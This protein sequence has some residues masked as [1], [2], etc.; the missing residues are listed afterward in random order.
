MA[1]KTATNP[2]REPVRDQIRAPLQFDDTDRTRLRTG[3][4]T[5]DPLHISDEILAR[6]REAGRDLN[7]KNCEV[8]GMPQHSY[9]QL[10]LEQGWRPVTHDM[11]PGVFATQDTKGSVIINGS[12]LM[13]RPIGLSKQAKDEELQRARSAVRV[14]E[15]KAAQTPEGQLQRLQP[16]IRTTVQPMEIPDS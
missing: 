8:V 3:N 5:V 10:M 7:W 14:G 6:F 11:V 15:R 4:Q 9:Q 12:M 16:D 1:T 2:V 13:E